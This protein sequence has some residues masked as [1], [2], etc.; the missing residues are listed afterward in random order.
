MLPS[1]RKMHQ[2]H[3][4]RHIIATIMNQ[5]LVD[6]HFRYFFITL[7]WLRIGNSKQKLVHFKL[8]KDHVQS[9]LLRNATTTKP[10]LDSDGFARKSSEGT[11]WVEM[12]RRARREREVVMKRGRARD[13]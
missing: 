4:P 1:K 9:Q 3:H 7:S 10:G 11:S 5:E 13:Q 2:H 6:R 12:L 8:L